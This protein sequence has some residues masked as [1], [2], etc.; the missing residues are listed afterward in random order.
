MSSYKATR[1]YGV[2]EICVFLRAID[3]HLTSHASIVLIGG[4]AAAFHQASST[5]NDVDTSH[6]LTAELR[7]AIERASAETGLAIPI[8]YAAV[9]DVPYNSDDRL[10]RLLPELG[11]LE[12]RVLEKHDLALSKIV[13]GDDHDLQQLLEIHQNTGLDFDILVGRFRDEMGHVVGDPVRIRRQ[14]LDLIH[15]LFGELK[16][17]AANKMLSS[18]NR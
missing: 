1:I 16:H 6:A 11:N 8:S 13:R 7:T 12:V 15:L 18:A 14:F 5:T 10:E 17:V 9:A 3:R 2:D 4:A